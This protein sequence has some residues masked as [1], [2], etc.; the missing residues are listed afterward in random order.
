MQTAASISSNP[1]RQN[2]TKAVVLDVWSKWPLL[3]FIPLSCLNSLSA[4]EPLA[5]KSLRLG[6]KEISTGCSS[7]WPALGL[8]TRR[9]LQVALDISLMGDTRNALA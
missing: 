7:L 1:R 6:G 5:E 2:G 4:T 8:A 9:S 3:K